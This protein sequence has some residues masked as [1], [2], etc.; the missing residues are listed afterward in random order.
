[1]SSLGFLVADVHVDLGYRPRKWQADFH[2]AFKKRAILIVHRR[3]GKTVVGRMELLD[4]ALNTPKTRYAYVAPYLK[5]ARSVMWGELKASALKIPETDV[6]EA[7]L[8]VT[9]ANGSTITCF[10]ADNADSLRGLGFHGLVLDEMADV[11]PGVM[12]QVLLPTL[13][14]DDGWL[15]LIG[16]PK[17]I[18]PLSELYFKVESDPEWYARRL[19][20]EDTGVFTPEQMA[21]QRAMQ[22]ER[23]Y[24]LEYCCLFDAGAPDTL[25]SGLDYDAATTR[26]IPDYEIDEHPIII[27][28]DVARYG[29]DRT[30]IAVR[31][32]PKL[33]E[34][35]VMRQAS[36]FDIA[37]RVSLV[38]HQY[39][40][41][42]VFI[43]Y[44]GGL[45]GGVQDQLANMGIYAVAVH[46]NGK[47]PDDHYRN[48]R[49][50][51]W[52]T[53]AK[54][55]RTTACLPHIPGLKAEITSPTY[56]TDDSGKLQLESKDDLKARGM[57]SPDQADAICLTHAH[58]VLPKAKA[59]TNQQP[60]EWDPFQ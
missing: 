17:G 32:G 49:A 22:T 27:G 38:Y 28:V 54:W 19:S 3:A 51:M 29:D 25:L 53:M 42:A 31:Q 15:L 11:K 9:F 21:E 46:F 39:H 14:A 58:P 2:R 16:T 56:H 50:Y 20:W 45:G 36:T 7:E 6:S 40:A 44:S 30:V 60:V 34:P 37:N 18:D 1:M 23:E 26:V 55:I 33:Y 48:M 4:H 57:S 41:D 52:F 47:P 24:L 10:G 12:G 35:V 43:D 59:R 8:R 5:Q 13:V